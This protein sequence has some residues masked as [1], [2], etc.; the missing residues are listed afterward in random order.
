MNDEPPMIVPSKY[1]GLMRRYSD[2]SHRREARLGRRGE[3]TVDVGELEPRVVERAH[4]RLRHEI[5]RARVGRDQ[6][7]VGFGGADDRDAAFLETAH[8]APSA[9]VNT[10]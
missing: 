3:N 2:K 5:D 8:F 4:R 1:F 10:G 7:Q 9:G 6:P